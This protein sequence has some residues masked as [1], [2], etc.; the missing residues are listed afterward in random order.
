MVTNGNG[1]QYCSRAS[2]I[3]QSR[4]FRNSALFGSISPMHVVDPTHFFGRLDRRN[5][6][7]HYDGFLTASHEYAFERLVSA[8]VDLLVRNVGRDID[9]VAGSCFSGELEMIAPTH[10]SA[11]FDDVDDALE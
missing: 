2:I 8:G 3:F 10:S 9:E 7:V 4:R 6:K 11:A 1:W 5:L